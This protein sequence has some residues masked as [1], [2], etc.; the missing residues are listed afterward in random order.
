MDFSLLV[1]GSENIG[2][3]FDIL[4]FVM[5][6][7]GFSHSFWRIVVLGFTND[8]MCCFLNVILSFYSLICDI[9]SILCI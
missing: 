2:V 7:C 9:F 3:F 5:L 8:T 1:L 4:S 6:V